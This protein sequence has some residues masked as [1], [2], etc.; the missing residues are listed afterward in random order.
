[1][2]CPFKSGAKWFAQNRG[3]CSSPLSQTLP[4]ISR[5]ASLGQPLAVAGDS[6]EGLEIN[7]L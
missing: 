3:R 7:L 6:L 2:T 4:G 5:P 1:M